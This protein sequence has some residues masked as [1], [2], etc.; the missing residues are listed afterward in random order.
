MNFPAPGWQPQQGFP[1]GQPNYGAPQ[2]GFQQQGYGQPQAPQPIT[3]STEDFWASNSGG[4][5][6]AP[7]FNFS[8][9]TPMVK[10]TITHMI[11]R[12]KTDPKTK[13][14]K[15]NKDG[16]TPQMQLEV[17]LQTD[18]RGWQAV[19]NV[20]GQTNPQTG[21]VVPLPPEQ[22]DGKRRIFLWYTL[23]DAVADAMTAAGVQ[24]PKVGDQLA[25]QYVGDQPNPVG[26]NPIKNY[27]AWIQPSS[28]EAQG[29][30]GQGQQQAP[31]TQPAATQQAQ[32]QAWGGP[33]PQNVTQAP[34]FP[35]A[36]QQQGFQAPPAQQ[37][38][39]QQPASFSPA[40]AEATGNGWGQAATQD[41]PF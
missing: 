26:G 8:Q 4:G 18:L 37:A 27:K 20:P 33:Q 19:K 12:Q 3:Q 9:E 10:G 29:F 25:V 6:G 30:F 36:A 39:A 24:A 40:Q 13:A 31:P 41:P 1:Q 5:G 7:S 11:A 21:Q 14:P 23:R 35:Q 32:Q 38:P 22:D 16:V 34:G 28:P 15:F 2:Q 17:T